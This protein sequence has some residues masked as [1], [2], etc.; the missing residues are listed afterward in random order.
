MTYGGTNVPLSGLKF[1]VGQKFQ[2]NVIFII[3]FL[4]RIIL[5]IQI[6]LSNEKVVECVKVIKQALRPFGDEK[7]RCNKEIKIR[8]NLAQL[9][10]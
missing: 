7:F 4:S 1:P 5:N 3:T 9:T 10:Q 6:N 8:L 2:I